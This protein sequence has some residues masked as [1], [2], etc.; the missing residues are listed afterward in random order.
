ML[1]V[2]AIFLVVA[3]LSWAGFGLQKYKAG[4]LAKAPFVKTNEA[5]TEGEK[6][7]GDKGAISVE[8]DVTCEEPLLSPIT[9]SEC[10][11][12]ELSVVAEWKAGEK[13]EKLSV[14]NE[15]Q[16]A[17]FTLDDGSGP[18][19]VDASGG[20]DF[21]DIKSSFSKKK[22]RGIVATSDSI[23]FGE[24]G[25]SVLTGQKINNRVIP[26][27]AKYRVE[28]KILAPVDHL[29]ANGKLT[30]ENTVGSPSWASLILTTKTREELVSGTEN[31]AK[32]LMYVAAASSVLGVLLA[33]IGAAMG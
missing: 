17:P 16:A 2:G 1:A 19:A 25:F 15:K 33:G 20:G 24:H 21:E 14:L 30:E 11:Y 28:E 9:K 7:A 32:K 3:A 13:N 26:Q 29:Y 22:G 27:S 5:A 6:V 31:F 23:E 12:Y 8:G 18:V 4:R 10:L